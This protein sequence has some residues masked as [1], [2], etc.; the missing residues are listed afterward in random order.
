MILLAPKYEN[1]IIGIL[2]LIRGNVV[3][4]DKLIDLD[5]NFFGKS[6]R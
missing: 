3:Y 6:C 4:Y 5:I 1:L 2:D